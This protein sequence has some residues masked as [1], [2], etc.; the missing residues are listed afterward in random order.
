MMQ[1]LALAFF[2]TAVAVWWYYAARQRKHRA[3]ALAARRNAPR[4]YHC[5][6]VR[7]GNP[8]CEAVRRF[9]NTRFLSDEAPMLPLAAE[10]RAPAGAWLGFAH[11]IKSAD[12][13]IQMRTAG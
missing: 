11:A 9:G 5:V 4:S 2:A 1:V 7:A 12:Y 3:A 8:A 6:D 13:G 10:R